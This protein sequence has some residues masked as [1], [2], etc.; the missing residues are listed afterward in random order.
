VNTA[1]GWELAL[2]RARQVWDGLVGAGYSDVAA[3]AIVG[4]AL[5]LWRDTSAALQSET[6]GGG[7]AVSG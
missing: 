1:E 5:G 6:A 3:A 7:P 4:L 2:L